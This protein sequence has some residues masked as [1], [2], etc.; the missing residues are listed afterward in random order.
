M[1]KKTLHSFILKIVVC[2]KRGGTQILVIYAP[3]LPPNV[4]IL[5]HSSVELL[6]DSATEKC[7]DHQRSPSGG[8]QR[9]RN[10]EDVQRKNREAGSSRIFLRS[11]FKQL[12][13]VLPLV[14]YENVSRDGGGIDEVA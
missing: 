8:D 11:L 1:S 12:I 13:C 7:Q 4:A 5:K 6:T 9:R 3:M 2:R 14:K 10:N